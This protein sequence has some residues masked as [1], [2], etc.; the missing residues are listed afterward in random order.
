[1]PRCLHHLSRCVPS[2]WKPRA[3][4]PT[5]PPP[6]LSRQGAVAKY[7]VPLG[8]NQRCPVEYGKVEWSG[9]QFRASVITGC[10][11]ALHS[12]LPRVEGELA[13]AAAGLLKRLG[14]YGRVH[15][16]VLGWARDDWPFAPVRVHVGTV[17]RKYAELR[18]SM[19]FLESQ[20]W[21]PASAR[22]LTE[23]VLMAIG[24]PPIKPLVDTM[25]ESVADHWHALCSWAHPQ[26]RDLP[27]RLRMARRGMELLTGEWPWGAAWV[28]PSPTP[29]PWVDRLLGNEP[30]VVLDYAPLTDCSCGACVSRRREIAAARRAWGTLGHQVLP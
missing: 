17:Y 9:R 14:E 28:E 8:L 4:S 19:E 22:Q 10:R 11:R 23:S 24:R 16:D 3:W 6:L 1:M 18:Q 15:D 27:G 21:L 2:G 30:R 26:R 13:A 7:R 20:P 5:T 29:P 12:S 25:P